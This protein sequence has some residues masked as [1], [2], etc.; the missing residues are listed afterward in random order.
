M[1]CSNPKCHHEVLY[2]I[3]CTQCQL[4]W[5]SEDPPPVRSYASEDLTQRARDPWAMA[6]LVAVVI[7]GILSVTSLLV[8]RP[9]MISGW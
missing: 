8:S 6:L 9:E 7:S 2:G 3:T 1:K 5:V 4:N